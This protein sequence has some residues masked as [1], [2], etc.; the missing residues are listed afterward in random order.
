MKTVDRITELEKASE[1]LDVE[2]L[3]A[4]SESVRGVIKQN[5]KENEQAINEIAL[6]TVHG[7][8]GLFPDHAKEY[9]V[10]KF[11]KRLSAARNSGYNEGIMVS[12]GAFLDK[13]PEPP[14][15]RDLLI[16]E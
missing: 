15:I 9:V 16:K 5:D 6:N 14:Q 11:E 1:G 3:G 4:V 2:I 10:G 13:E 7:A 12:R 8:L